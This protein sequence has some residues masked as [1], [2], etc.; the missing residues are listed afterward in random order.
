MDLANPNYT[1]FGCYFE[2]KFRLIQSPVIRA[3]ILGLRFRAKSIVHENEPNK[4]SLIDGS[5]P[6]RLHQVLFKQARA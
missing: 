1:V 2:Q 4:K 3:L 6:T 5:D